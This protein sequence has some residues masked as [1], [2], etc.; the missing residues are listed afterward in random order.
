VT[1]REQTKASLE[2]QMSAKKKR[3]EDAE[4][5]ELNNDLH[6][7]HVET[8]AYHKENQQTKVTKKSQM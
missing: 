3:K 2:A 5:L 8:A 1:K 4:Q 7:I 6:N